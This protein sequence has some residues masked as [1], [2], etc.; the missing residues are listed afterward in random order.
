[1]TTPG[2]DAL[3][4]PSPAAVGR[5]HFVAQYLKNLTRAQVDAYHAAGV[6]VV[7]V[8]ETTGQRSLSGYAAGVLDGKAALAA[9][10]L[11]GAPPTVACYFA[12]DDFNVTAAQAPTVVA[13]MRGVAS[14]L[15]R[16]RTGFY[17]G[18]LAVRAVQAAGITAYEWQ[19]YAWSGGQWAPSTELQQYL[20][21]QTLAGT[22]VDYDRA[23]VPAY[24]A[25]LAP[26]P[27]SSVVPVT[28][29]PGASLMPVIIRQTSTGRCDLLDGGSMEHIAAPPQYN[30]LAAA[31]VPVRDVDDATFAALL[32][33]FPPL[34]TRILA[35]LSQPVIGDEDTGKPGISVLVALARGMSQ[36][37][38]ARVLSGRTAAWLGI[39]TDVPI[40]PPTSEDPTMLDPGNAEV[41]IG[42]IVAALQPVLAAG[43]NPQDVADAVLAGMRA[44]PQ[45]LTLAPAP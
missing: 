1:M 39:R 40:G 4:H 27:V 35:A 13:Y 28:P 25:W 37:R 32:A 18:L 45:T 17:G 22:G 30:A 41:L 23:T 38:K 29:K 8:W 2:Y 12:E 16:A 19:T 15:G 20:N 10:I 24:G 33:N 3:G 9:M 5:G 44:H 6:H 11:L 34:Q 14:V 26:T 43:A 42:S 36:S 7:L 31:G 21:G